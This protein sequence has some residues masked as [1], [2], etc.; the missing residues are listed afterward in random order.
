[1][2]LLNLDLIWVNRT[3]D[4]EVAGNY[5]TAVL[6][7]RVLTLVPGA[8]LV[9][10]YPRAVARIAEGRL[11]DS[12]LLKTAAAI[13]LPTLALIA[14]YFTFGSDLVVLAFGG[15]YTLPN[16]LLG[17]VAV[18]MLGYSFASI[19][20]NL[21]LAT[22]PLPFVLLI[23]AAAIVQMLLYTLSTPHCSRSSPFSA[24]VAGP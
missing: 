21:Y 20:M 18:G 10:M 2:S 19:W 24:S 3:F 13:T 7:R 12:L 1:M 17:W 14:L 23:T 15:N 6:L 16:W 8:M 4:P 11:P 5:A 9:I 22:R